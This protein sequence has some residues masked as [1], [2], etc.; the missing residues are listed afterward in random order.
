M[1]RGSRSSSPIR[2]PFVHKGFE[3]G[4]FSGGGAGVRNRSASLISFQRV[5]HV[6]H[7]RKYEA[8]LGGGGFGVDESVEGDLG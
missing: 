2:A 8:E 5:G 7:A 3:P 4:L 6:V 1:G